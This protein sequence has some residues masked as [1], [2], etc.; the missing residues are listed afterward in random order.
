MS[1]LFHSPRLVSGSAVVVV[2]ALALAACSSGDEPEDSAQPLGGV[3]EGGILEVGLDPTICI[4]PQQTF[5]FSAAAVARSITDSLTDQD[6][7]TGEIVPWLAESWTIND[8]ATSYTFTLR[9]GITFSDGT[10]LDAETAA[11]NIHYIDELGALSSRGTAYL[12]NFESAEAIDDLTFQ[13]DF[14]RPSAHFLVGTSTLVFS[15]LSNSTMELTPEERCQ[16]ALVGTGPFVVESYIQDQQIDVIR[17]EGYQWASPLASH[18]GEA[19]LDG[20]TF[21]SQPVANVRA[22]SLASGQTD[23]ALALETQ[24]VASVEAS[25]GQILVGTMPGLPGTFFPNLNREIPAD[26]E[27]RKAF[28]HGIDAVSIVD[29]VLQGYY[30]PATSII[31]SNLREYVDHSGDLA[32]DPDLAAEILDEA[33]WAQGP[34]GVRVRDGVP[35]AFDILYTEDFGDFYTSLLQLV[36][37]QL[38]EIGIDVTLR[39]LPAAAIWAASMEFDY[40][41][42]ITTITES[43]PDMARSRLQGLFAE[44]PILT[45]LGLEELF[46]AQQAAADQVERN[47]IW[48]EIQ[49]IA[50]ENMLGIPLFEGTQ[51]T[52]ISPDVTGPRYDFKSMLTF[53]DTAFI[54]Q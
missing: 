14:A 20:I 26:Q 36:Q 48:E 24:D 5:L 17:R 34:D 11:R 35:L 19:Y 43:D 45:E 41:F 15:M 46:T 33:G 52:G 3:V 38:R 42:S 37:Q 13:V 7:M 21:L 31:T 2:A 53:Y 22:G 54:E 30:S 9:E 29:T 28:A 44:S 8:D 12:G 4:D 47:A 51:I 6:P 18:E 50:F 10:P 23:V 32:Y 39:N 27:V 1:S 40:D 49:A 25:G 16:G